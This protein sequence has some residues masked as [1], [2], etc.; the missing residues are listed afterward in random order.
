MFLETIGL[1]FKALLRDEKSTSACIFFHFRVLF[2]AA[3]RRFMKFKRSCDP[4]KFI[5]QAFFFLSS[6]SRS[7]LEGIWHY[8]LTF[9]SL[10]VDNISFLEEKLSKVAFRSRLEASHFF[11]LDH[12]HYS[13]VGD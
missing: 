1:Y 7:L 9:E 4:S 8:N 3:T 5:I 12:T 10:S 11:C 6:E 13:L 2:M